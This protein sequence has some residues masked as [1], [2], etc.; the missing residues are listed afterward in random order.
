MRTGRW[1][2]AMTKSI[3]WVAA[4]VLAYTLYELHVPSGKINPVSTIQVALL[5]IAVYIL[6]SLVGWLVIGL[7]V[8]FLLCAF[9]CKYFYLYPLFALAAALGLLG[10]MDG[11]GAALLGVAAILQATIFRYYVFSSAPSGLSR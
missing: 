2:Q 6:L 10:F 8:H 4:Y 11:E 3:L 5:F 1:A 9:G 7:P